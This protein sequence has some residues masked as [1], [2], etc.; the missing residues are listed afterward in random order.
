MKPGWNI[1]IDRGGTFT[2][3]IAQRPDGSLATLKLLSADPQ[4]YADP[5]REGIE[6]ILGHTEISEVEAQ[7]EGETA[8]RGTLTMGKRS[9]AELDGPSATDA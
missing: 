7:V 4:R 9:A 8:V 6:R 2:D 3:V 5:V 1:W